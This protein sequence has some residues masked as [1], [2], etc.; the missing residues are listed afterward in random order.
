[1]HGVISQEA[2]TKDQKSYPGKI[3]DMA[4]P[5]T[6]YL[7]LPDD[8]QRFWPGDEVVCDVTKNFKTQQLL[9]ANLRL[10]K[11]HERPR[12]RG[13]INSLAE[14]IQD[15][16]LSSTEFENEIYFDLRDFS[17]AADKAKLA[18]RKAFP[19]IVGTEIEFSVLT[20]QLGINRAIHLTL[21][22]KEKSAKVQVSFDMGWYIFFFKVCALLQTESWCCCCGSATRC[23]ANQWLNF[24]QWSGKSATY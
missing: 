3:Q 5:N 14:K 23:R 6:E 22:P 24:N 21:I 15:G 16:Y 11:S 7:F 13:V 12:Y 10:M 2:L 20:D 17:N 19:Q 8:S 4:N 9:G 18:D 1:M